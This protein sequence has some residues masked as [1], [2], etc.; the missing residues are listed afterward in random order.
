MVPIRILLVDDT[1]E[2]LRVF[3]ETLKQRFVQQGIYVEID[4]KLNTPEALDHLRETD[5]YDIV[6]LD[7]VGV[8]Y[9]DFL[10]EVK[11]SYP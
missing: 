4:I 5:P 10:R 6:L 11:D 9:E 3:L 2:E 1:P 7:I 8:R